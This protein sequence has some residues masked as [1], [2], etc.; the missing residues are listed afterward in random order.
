MKVQSSQPKSARRKVGCCL[1]IYGIFVF[2]VLFAMSN[3]WW[4]ATHDDAIFRVA[5]S[6]DIVFVALIIII[7]IYKGKQHPVVSV[8]PQGSPTH[9]PPMPIPADLGMNL[10][11]LSEPDKIPPS[12]LMES[13]NNQTTVQNADKLNSST[14]GPSSIACP[15]CGGPLRETLTIDKKTGNSVKICEQCKILV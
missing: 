14:E 9:V 15:K 6:T 13:L 1:L 5:L 10:E 3:A 11:P 7:I 8:A 4:L 2:A 12:L